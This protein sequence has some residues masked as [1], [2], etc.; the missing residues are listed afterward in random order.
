M[1]SRGRARR[2]EEARGEVSFGVRPSTPRQAPATRTDSGD[3]TSTGDT[4]ASGKKTGSRD[5]TIL[6][7]TRLT[8]IRQTDTAAREAAG[9]LLRRF[10]AEE[11]S[12][13]SRAAQAR[14]LD[15][16]IDD[17]RHCVV[18]VAWPGPTAADHESEHGAPPPPVGIATA[19]WSP[20]VE[21]VRVARM[22]AVYVS[23]AARRRGLGTA[24]VAAAAAWAADQGCTALLVGVGPDGELSHGLTGFF[25][26]RGFAED[27]R[28][29]LS[30]ALPRQTP[31]DH[32]ATTPPEEC[33]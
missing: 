3:T 6:N 27:Y 21:H 15:E 2:R 25:T 13:A 19:T 1:P 24:L 7:D 4:T 20:S 8:A 28:N 31:G 9:G 17:P 10:L 14:G 18:L 11:G 26:A 5:T 33:T 22:D 23:P 16:M 29:L 12:G 32:L 30:L